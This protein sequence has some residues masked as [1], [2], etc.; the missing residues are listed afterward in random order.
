[1]ENFFRIQKTA[2]YFTAG[3]PSA[4]KMV[5]VLHGYGQLAN[6]FIRKFESVQDEYFVVCP[7][8][9][10]RFYTKGHSG[11]VGASWM[12]KEGRELDI[13]DN[14]VYIT[15][16]VNHLKQENHYEEVVILG[17][18]Q[19]GA[20]AARV[21]F[22]TNSVFTKLVLWA[23]I[24]PPDLSSETVFKKSTNKKNHKFVVGTSDEFFTDN[25]LVELK[26]Y[27]EEQNFEV[28]TFD[29]NHDI[30]AKTLEHVLLKS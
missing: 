16:L 29:G 21:Y 2:R 6:Y 22:N 10:H 12:T 19:S 5:V 7:E 25:Q 9:T 13:Q 1:M 3:N 4:K 14:E 18:S 26:K 24:L 17:F 27:F 20:T 23:S 11:R 30:D 28:I 8:A 15:Q